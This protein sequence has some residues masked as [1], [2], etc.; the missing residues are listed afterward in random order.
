MVF[1]RE[2][3]CSQY[4]QPCLNFI[5]CLTRYLGKDQR[6]IAQMHLIHS[7]RGLSAGSQSISRFSSKCWC[8]PLNPKWIA[9]Y[10]LINLNR[11]LTESLHTLEY[12]TSN[13]LKSQSFFSPCVT[14]VKFLHPVLVSF[15]M[16]VKLAGW[17]PCMV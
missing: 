5:I 12:S 17:K 4:Q 7:Y 2:K 10:L 3:T 14:V 15:Q 8:G 1:C 11:T 6:S 9:M 13:H 16:T